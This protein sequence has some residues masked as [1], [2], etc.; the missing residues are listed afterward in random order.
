MRSEVDLHLATTVELERHPLVFDRN[1]LAREAAGQFQLETDRRGDQI[2]VL[3]RF[4][5]RAA[6]RPPALDL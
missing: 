4:W 3:V 2:D 6:A 1:D 5:Q